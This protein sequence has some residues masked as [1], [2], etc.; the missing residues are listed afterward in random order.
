[1]TSF[2]KGATLE[3]WIQKQMTQWQNTKKLL[4]EKPEV[5]RPFVTISREYGC[6]ATSV[7]VVLAAELNKYE[8]TELWHSYDKDLIEKI[9]QDHQISETLM[10][11]I[12]T[13]KREEM[14]ELVRSMLT[15]YPPQVVAYKKL[16]TTIRSLCI[17]GHSI[18]VGRAGV[19]ITRGLRHGVHVKFVA[20]LGYRVHKVKEINGIKDKLEAEKLVVKKDRER[21]DFLTQYIKFDAYNPASYDVTVNI[22]S[23]TEKQVAEIIIS[24]LKAKGL[25]R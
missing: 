9:S 23:F 2:T 7:A 18:I 14:S 12:D 22:A 17:H 5:P 13:K 15:D 25:I 24:A 10:E 3:K 11:T 6:N 1:M 16:V 4:E 19:V 8:K 20:P 21:H